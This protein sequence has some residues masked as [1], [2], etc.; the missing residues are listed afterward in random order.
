[1]LQFSDKAVAHIKKLMTQTPN[2]CGFRLTIKET[3]CS[4]FMYMPVIVTKKPE[5]DL[6]L[7]IQELTIF[8]DKNCVP[9]IEGTKVDLVDKGLGQQ[10]LVFYNP[11]ATGQCGCGES[12]KVEKE[13]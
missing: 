1:M 8:L 3:G 13:Q 2:A 10:Q 11:N 5:A 6:A 7:T 4:G 12:F 9:L